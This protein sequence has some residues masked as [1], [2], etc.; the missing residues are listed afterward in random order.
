MNGDGDGSG[1]RARGGAKRKAASNSKQGAAAKAE[2]DESYEVM[3]TKDGG[4]GGGGGVQAAVDRGD[5]L[6]DVPERPA[7]GHE[8]RTCK[9]CGGG[10][11]CQHK[12]VRSR[13]KERTWI[14]G[15]PVRGQRG[16]HFEPPLHVT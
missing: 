2:G 15:T 8:R 3:P 5:G 7:H 14:P 13:C 1:G 11:I 9:G 16:H 4:W 12:R 6:V 10:S